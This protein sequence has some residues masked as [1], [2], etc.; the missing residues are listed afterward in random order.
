LAKPIESSRKLA[1]ARSKA[2][3]SK[4]SSTSTNKTLSSKQLK[5]FT[6]NS[7]GR[8]RAAKSP[9]TAQSSSKPASGH[10]KGG[11]K[12]MCGGDFNACRAPKCTAK[13]SLNP[14]TSSETSTA[15]NIAKKYI[16]ETESIHLQFVATVRYF[17]KNEKFAQLKKYRTFALNQGKWTKRER[18]NVP[19]FHC[20]QIAWTSK[21]K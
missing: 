14:V 3:N 5:S 8:R 6:L 17:S 13:Y 11:N 16:L 12:V 1:K 21:P 9:N 15:G 10:L 20:N 7:K 4:Q 2:S 18:K 19:S